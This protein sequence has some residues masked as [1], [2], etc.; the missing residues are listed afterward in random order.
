MSLHDELLAGL[1]P[2]LAADSV[3]IGAH[4]TAVVSGSRCGLSTTLAPRGAPHARPSVKAAGELAGRPLIELARLIRSELPM[5]ACVGMAAINAGLPR[6]GLQISERNGFEVLLER[7]R[8]A[9]LVIVGH[10]SFVDK[11][12]GHARETTVLE[13]DPRA[14][15]LPASADERVIPPAEVVAI[16]G[17]AF[18]N[19]TIE[20]LLELTRGKWVMVL[21][22]TTPL[23]PLL[24]D[25]GISALAGSLVSDVAL[26][27]RQIREGAIFKQLTGVR[28]VMLERRGGRG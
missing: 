21:G 23:S 4:L 5:E 15:D 19:R 26:T 6:E 2:G 27:V 9:R 16:T 14:G 25:H 3:N 13:L 10:F 7:S 12:I 22:P 18:A 20:K 28:R 24:F 8:G 1:D 11:L 17:S